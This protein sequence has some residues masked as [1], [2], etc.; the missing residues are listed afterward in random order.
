VNA[1]THS[2]LNSTWDIPH[3]FLCRVFARSTD[4]LRVTVFAAAPFD[5][6]EISSFTKNFL[7]PAPQPI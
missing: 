4:T 1:R 5:T 2:P 7:G 3:V 6:R